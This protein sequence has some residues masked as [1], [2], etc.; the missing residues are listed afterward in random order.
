MRV[1][2]SV[3]N[4]AV[5]PCSAPRAFTRSRNAGG[6]AYSRPHS[7][8]TFTSSS[9]TAGSSDPAH[10]RA[11]VPGAR[12]VHHPLDHGL[13]V[14]GPA[15]HLELPIRARA[16]LDDAVNVLQRRA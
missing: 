14:A 8:P 1:P 2:A 4:S 12:F 7:S 11:L 6:K 9:A 10:R 15:E 3:T 16:L 13:Q 5:M